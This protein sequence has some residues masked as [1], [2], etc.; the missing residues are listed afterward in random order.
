MA[1]YITT[2]NTSYLHVCTYG[3]PVRNRQILNLLIFLQFNSD[4]GY[5]VVFYCVIIYDEYV[6]LNHTQVAELVGET[7]EHVWDIIS[8]FAP[9]LDQL[10]QKDETIGNTTPL[11]PDTISNQY[12]RRVADNLIDLSKKFDSRQ[13]VRQSNFRILL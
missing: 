4:F 9:Q 2:A 13:Q 10:Q 12:W 5:E 3:N 11:D 6:I 7:K 1:V 8:K